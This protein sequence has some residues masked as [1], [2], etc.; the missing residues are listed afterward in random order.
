MMDLAASVSTPGSVTQVTCDIAAGRP[1]WNIFLSGRQ[2]KL[3]ALIHVFSL[4]GR[5][6]ACGVLLKEQHLCCSRSCITALRNADTGGH[7]GEG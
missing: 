4:S 1:L 7:C 2:G 3:V 5:K 6:Q